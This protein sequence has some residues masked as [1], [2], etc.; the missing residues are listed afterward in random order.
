MDPMTDALVYAA[1]ARA[2]VARALLGR[3]CAATGVS[4]RLDVYGT[5]GLYQRLGPRRAPP[6][7]D[8]VFWFGPYAA[9]AAAVDGLLQ[10]YQP[11]SVVNDVLHDPDWKWTTLDYSAIGVIGA[12][13]VTL[14]DLAQAP[15]LAIADPERSEVGM[16]LLLAS[17][18]RFRQVEGDAERGWTWWQ[19]RAQAGLLL[20]EDDASALALVQSG[21]ATH[22]LTLDPSGSPL[23]GVA[24]LPHAVGLPSS[25]RNADAGHTLLD[26]LTSADAAT[27]LTLSPW[28]ADGNGLAGLLQSAPQLDVDWARQQY[29][30]ARQRWAASAFGPTLAS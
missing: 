1:S 22:A 9:R 10:A 29:V 8:A 7:P 27:G 25:S 21:S 13:V 23:Q 16:C 2:D 11:T 18:D 28:Q 20:A 19:Q 12:G 26:W 15:R 30:A 5:G 17:L 4:A 6:M 24:P 3:G 14:I